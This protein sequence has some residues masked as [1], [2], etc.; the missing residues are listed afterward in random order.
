MLIELMLSAA[1][2]EPDKCNEL[3]LASQKNIENAIE[4]NRKIAQGLVVPDFE[5]IPLKEQLN[6]LAD[7]MLKKAGMYV[8]IDSSSLQEELL[9]DEQRLTIYRIAQEQYTNIIKHAAAG[10]VY[11]L[12]H[13]SEGYFK[14]LIFDNG[15]GQAAGTKTTG[16]G[17]RNIKG[18]LGLFN[19]TAKVDA[20]PGRGF[21][22]EVVIPLAPGKWR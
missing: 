10:F 11:I 7:I 2:S 19:G 21:T 1:L 5:T 17:L 3:V 15:K 20:T 18:R 6:H 12:L 16:I 14:K 13:T 22:L 4:E 8:F 9:D